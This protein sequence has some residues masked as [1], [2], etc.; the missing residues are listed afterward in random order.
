MDIRKPKAI[1]SL[2]EFA[3]ELATIVVG[4]LIALGAEAIV[5]QHRISDAVEFSRDDF[6]HELEQNRADVE[7]NLHEAHELDKQVAAVLKD[8]VAFVRGQGPLS[9]GHNVSRT[10]VRL[11]SAAWSSALSTQVM[12][13]FPHEEGRA[14]AQ[15]Y[16]EQQ[17][18]TDLQQAEQGVWFNLA[19]ASFIGAPTKPDVENAM[20]HLVVARAYLAAHEES[21]EGLLRT[22]DDALKR[23]KHS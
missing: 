13:H 11:R 14:V 5:E 3:I 20:K 12:G 19:D 9:G 7:R 21:E 17:A 23:L 18:F 15:A 8:G 6:I 16:N 2:R 1:G 4:V 10:F 22:Y